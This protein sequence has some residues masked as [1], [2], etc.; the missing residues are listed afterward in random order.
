M[1]VLLFTGKGGVG[2]TTA[3]AGTAV[4]I[5]RRGLRTLVLSTDA[6]H[7]LGG[8]GRHIAVDDGDATPDG[9]CSWD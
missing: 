6:A 5:G 1:R 4:L 9:D 8:A 3:A 2:K 7:S